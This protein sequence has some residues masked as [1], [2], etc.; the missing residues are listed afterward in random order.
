SERY[1]VWFCGLTPQYSAALWIGNDVNIP[2][3][4]GSG[5]AATLWSRIMQRVCAGLPREEFQ[6]RGDFVTATV[7]R[8]SGKLPTSLSTSDPRG[9]LVSDIFIEGTVPTEYDD[10]HV[11]VTVCADTGYLAT[12]YC[13]DTVSKLA[14]IRPNGSSWEKTLVNYS[15]YSVGLRSLPDAIYDAPEFYCPEHNPN[16]SAYPIS[17]FAPEKEVD[18]PFYVDPSGNVVTGGAITPPEDEEPDVP[19]DY[20]NNPPDPQTEEQEDEDN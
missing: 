6:M 3:N 20:G 9:T 17:P 12:P 19:E 8:I 1:D 10:A 15:M 7:D 18:N 4:Q 2:M 14:V 16:P 11:L 5:A 13:V